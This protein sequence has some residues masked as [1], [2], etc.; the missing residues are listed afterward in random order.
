MDL[1][2]YHSSGAKNFEVACRFLENVCT[3]GHDHIV[4]ECEGVTLLDVKQTGQ[5][6][7]SD[8]YNS[9]MKELTMFQPHKKPM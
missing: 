7:N 3:S 9:V 1:A 4:W 5:A 2:S 6:F 8:T